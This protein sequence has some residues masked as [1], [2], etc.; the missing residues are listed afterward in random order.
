MPEQGLLELKQLS[1]MGLKMNIN[2]LSPLIMRIYIADMIAGIINR[3][4]DCLTHQVQ[5]R[6]KKGRK[7]WGLVLFDVLMILTY[8]IQLVIFL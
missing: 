1:E 7:W 6:R 8:I 3:N 2:E 4:R 5:T